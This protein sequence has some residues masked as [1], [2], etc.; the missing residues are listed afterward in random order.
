MMMNNSNDLPAHLFRVKQA[1]DT[2]SM[3]PAT[4]ASRFIKEMEKRYGSRDRSWT[5]VGFEFR[6]GGP[7]IWFPGSH[8]NPP[9]KHIAI[10]LSTETFSDRQR[11][12]YQLA[13]ECVH[14]L[15]PV[16]GGGAPVIEEGL[17]TAFSEDMIEY[18]CGNTNKQAYTSTQK[19]I[20]AAARVR[21]LL[22]LEPD[23][24]PRLRAVEPA[25]NQMTADTFTRAG[26]NVPP[27]LVAALL[28][29]FPKD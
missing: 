28:A 21:E 2:W 7:H 3:T 17:A 4:Y 27:V 22:A 14:L 1:N 6:E 25:F 5:Y 8:D 13:H 15:A 19:Y 23:A 11:M 16:V 24:I 29:S 10:S 12:V 9:R 26:L 20:D 18:W